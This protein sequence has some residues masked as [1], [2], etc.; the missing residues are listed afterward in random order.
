MTRKTGHEVDN[1]EED[2]ILRLAALVGTLHISGVEYT[3]PGTFLKVTNASVLF[4]GVALSVVT[5]SCSGS[6][7]HYKANG[8]SDSESHQCTNRSPYVIL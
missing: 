2:G 4:G 7:K 6:E 8:S 1:C 3:L 5:V